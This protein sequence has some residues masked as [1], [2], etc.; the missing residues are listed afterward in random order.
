M[1]EKTGW[2]AF[3]LVRIMK[4]KLKYFICIF[5]LGI[6]A[7]I[8]ADEPAMEQKSLI[9]FPVISSETLVIALRKDLPP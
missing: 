4:Q 7:N 9:G 5:L 2:D 1:N 3:G 8:S 6:A